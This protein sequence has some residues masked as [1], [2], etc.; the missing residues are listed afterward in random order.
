MIALL[1]V[2]IRLA[3]R[4]LNR[5]RLRTLLTMLGIIIGVA[6]V[7]TMVAIARALV[8]HP[9][10]ILADEPTGNL[11]SRTSIEILD[12]FQH[13]NREQGITVVLVTHEPDI[14][15]YAG[16]VITFRDGQ[17]ISDA[18]QTAIRADAE[19]A[20]LEENAG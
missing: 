9:P 20:A 13:L 4:S 16:R 7:L 6:A 17:V 15:T 2:N 11:D 1:P 10:L 12:V 19:V 3:L 18:R 5:N 8:N 14:S